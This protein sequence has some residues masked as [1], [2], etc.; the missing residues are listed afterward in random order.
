MGKKVEPTLFLE[1][2]DC[3]KDKYSITMICDCMGVPRAT[4]YRCRHREDGMTELEKEI[5]AIC[6]Q[7]KFHV[8]H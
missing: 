3:F 7:L 1:L 2:V 6:E 4:Y 5:L 8:G